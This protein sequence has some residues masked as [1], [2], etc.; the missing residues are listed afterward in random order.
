MKIK[1]IQLELTTKCNFNCV[2]CMGRSLQQTHMSVDTFN[3]II[4]SIEDVEFIHLQGEGESLLNK[5]FFDVISRL[6]NRFPKSKLSLITN[7]SLFTE[8]NIARLISSG[9]GHIS[10]SIESTNIKQY[11][12]IR[13]GKQYQLSDVIFGIQNM[14]KMIKSTN[15]TVEIG[16]SVTVL[17]STS[18]ELLRIVNL[19]KA[20]GMNGGITIQP[21]QDMPVYYGLYGDALRKEVPSSLDMERLNKSINNN[22]TLKSVFFTSKINSFF[23]N[24]YGENKTTGCPWLDNGVFITANGKATTCCYSREETELKDID[25]LRRSISG[26]LMN[27]DIPT[28]CAKCKISESLL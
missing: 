22:I 16:F 11:D 3:L 15:S 18:H 12:T 4:N 1:F 23:P 5:N 26:R 21:L 20:L 6:I 13:N 14:M 7:G 27:K 8:T 25:I 2:F 28:Q 17:K 19:Y 10:V 24:L 9:I